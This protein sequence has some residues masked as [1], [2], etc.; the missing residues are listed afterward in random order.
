MSPAGSHPAA[1]LKT[2]LCVG[3]VASPPVSASEPPKSAHASPRILS[4]SR[5]RVRRLPCRRVE[6]RVRER[7]RGQRGA[8]RRGGASLAGDERHTRVVASELLVEADGEEHVEVVADGGI[9]SRGGRARLPCRV[10]WL[11]RPVPPLPAVDPP[12]DCIGLQELH[13]AAV[14]VD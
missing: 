6:C 2:S 7:T 5:I 8:R 1:H 4:P 10:L 11:R 12:T 14:V 9:G 3:T 13:A